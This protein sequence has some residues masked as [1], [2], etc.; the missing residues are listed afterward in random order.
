[1]KLRRMARRRLV[2]L[3]SLALAALKAELAALKAGLA[4][5]ETELAALKVGLPA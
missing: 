5:L 1:M 4:G 3:R 2:E